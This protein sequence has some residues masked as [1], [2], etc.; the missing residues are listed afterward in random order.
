MSSPRECAVP[1]M[2]SLGMA[3]D[4]WQI[5]VLESSHPRLLLNCSR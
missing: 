3:P 4:P 5:E 2:R 1:L